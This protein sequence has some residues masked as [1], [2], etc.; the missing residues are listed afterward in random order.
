[1][2][3]TTE[4]TPQVNALRDSNQMDQLKESSQTQN[5]WDQQN[6]MIS[7]DYTVP[8][9]SSNKYNLTPR[10]QQQE[11]LRQSP[12]SQFKNKIITEKTIYITSPYSRLQIEN[13]TDQFIATLKCV[14]SY[15]LV[16]HTYFKPVDIPNGDSVV[17]F[18]AMDCGQ[19]V[20]LHIIDNDNRI[21]K[22]TE[23]TE[24]TMLLTIENYDDLNIDPQDEIVF[25][26]DTAI[27]QETEKYNKTYKH[28]KWSLPAINIIGFVSTSGTC[29]C[30]MKK[31]LQAVVN[32]IEEHCLKK[33]SLTSIQLDGFKQTCFALLFDK[34]H[35][36][37]N[38]NNINLG[39]LSRNLTVTKNWDIFPL[40]LDLV[41]R[42]AIDICGM[43]HMDIITAFNQDLIIFFNPGKVEY[44]SGRHE[45]VGYNLEKLSAPCEAAVRSCE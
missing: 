29:W 24:D 42:K 32:I 27:P 9:P 10:D 36:L 18:C 19:V 26:M 25:E 15:H 33:T 23:S 20:S 6:G 13:S 40:N 12:M 31:E 21:I 34:Y 39:S 37:W 1:M 14:P 28:L 8:P 35:P 7:E 30:D 5:N 45:V 2:K 22:V 3:L 44:Q 4:A 11:T 16:H 17:C 41:L 38:T 43:K